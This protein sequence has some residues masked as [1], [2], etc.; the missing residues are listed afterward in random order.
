MVNGIGYVV[1]D[2]LH[3]VHTAMSRNLILSVEFKC[4][5]CHTLDTLRPW[6]L[7]SYKR[8]EKWTMGSPSQTIF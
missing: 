6:I 2:I 3:E 5:K 1:S 8:D 4:I 7:H